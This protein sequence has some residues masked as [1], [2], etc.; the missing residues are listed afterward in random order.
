MP[1]SINQFL[2]VFVAYKAAIWP[3]QT[4]SNVRRSRSCGLLAKR[5]SF[6]PPVGL[7]T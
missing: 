5:M 6:R 4:L 1:F 2:D 7:I 3:A